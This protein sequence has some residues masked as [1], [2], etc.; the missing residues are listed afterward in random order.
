MSRTPVSINPFLS[1]LGPPS[2]NL[3]IAYSGGSS[4]EPE[5]TD[6]I[7]RVTGAKRSGERQI[8]PSTDLH[9]SAAHSPL[10]SCFPAFQS[11]DI[12]NGKKI[13]TRLK[14][15]RVH[16]NGSE[17]QHYNGLQI[18]LLSTLSVGMEITKCCTKRIKAASCARTLAKRI[19]FTEPLEFAQGKHGILAVAPISC[20]GIPKRSST[21]HSPQSIRSSVSGT[22]R[23]SRSPRRKPGSTVSWLVSLQHSSAC[24]HS[25]TP[26]ERNKGSRFT[27]QW[28]YESCA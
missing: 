8:A 22:C 25:R 2:L 13:N 6:H 5:S 17:S 7:N 11:S 21:P 16:Y 15:P 4:P 18:K 3:A 10:I 27:K 23:Y 20:S 1:T 19:S 26:P 9:N 12:S 28:I 24:D 14:L